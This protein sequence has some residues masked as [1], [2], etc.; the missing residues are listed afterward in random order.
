MSFWG[1]KISQ[2][3]RKRNF[4]RLF[5]KSDQINSEDNEI[6]AYNRNLAQA[7]W[8]IFD[9]T[10]SEILD[11]DDED[12]ASVTSLDVSVWKSAPTDNEAP[13]LIGKQELG[14][15]VTPVDAWIAIHGLVYDVTT[16]LSRHPGGINEIM[17]GVGKD[18]TKLFMKVIKLY[19]L[20]LS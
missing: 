5:S 4:G 18:S 7:E 11:D 19:D 14:H 2:R 15:H 8:P 6:A 17:K 12:N 3:N 13:P 10:Q 9:I 16:F 20:K 1:R